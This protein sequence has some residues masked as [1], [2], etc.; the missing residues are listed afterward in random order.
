MVLAC[1]SFSFSDRFRVHLVHSFD[2]EMN[3]IIAIERYLDAILLV[4]METEVFVGAAT[5]WSRW[6]ASPS[7]VSSPPEIRT[8]F[9]FVFSV[10]MSGE[11]QQEQTQRRFSLK[12]TVDERIEKA[13]DS[14]M[15]TVDSGG[16]WAYARH[17][18]CA[19]EYKV[20]IDCLREERSVAK[21]L[22]CEKQFKA[23]ENYNLAQRVKEV[24]QRGG[25]VYYYKAEMERI[26][27]GERTV[28][29]RTERTRSKRENGKR[30]RVALLAMTWLPRSEV[31]V[32]WWRLIATR[33]PWPAA[34]ANA[35]HACIKFLCTFLFHVLV[36]WWRFL[37]NVVTW[38]SQLLI[39]CQSCASSWK[40]KYVYHGGQ[41]VA[42]QHTPNHLHVGYA[43]PKKNFSFQ[44]KE[45][46]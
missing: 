1:F 45:F 8:P 22:P 40:L 15:E 10:R 36:P 35:L 34:P 42:G 11:S 39:L 16:R 4:S 17:L 26:R 5:A 30:W 19:L 38:P 25:N 28:W 27:K 14:Y 21:C 29:A 37:S 18:N 3:E 7:L 12:A 44:K 31:L 33:R 9:C 13:F 43:L 6:R 46:C 32:W 24:E 41:F 20:Y 23:C 2:Q